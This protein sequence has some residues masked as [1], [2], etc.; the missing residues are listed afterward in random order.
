MIATA[1]KPKYLL[2]CQNGAEID[3]WILDRTRQENPTQYESG[4]Q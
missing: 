1:T 3:P 2:N 4:F